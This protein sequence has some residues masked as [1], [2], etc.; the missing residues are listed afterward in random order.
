LC[1]Y[2]LPQSYSDDRCEQ[3]RPTL[4]N[5]ASTEDPSARQPT[6]TTSSLAVGMPGNVGALHECTKKG[7]ANLIRI[8]VPE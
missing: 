7:Q 5:D 8:T 2:N 6:L 3:Y 4:V 1:D